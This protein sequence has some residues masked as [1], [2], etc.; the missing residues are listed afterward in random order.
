MSAR[1]GELS[2]VSAGREQMAI[3]CS[4]WELITDTCIYARWGD[5]ILRTHHHHCYSPERTR[6]WRRPFDPSH[7]GTHFLQPPHRSSQFS[8]LLAIPLSAFIL[9]TLHSFHHCQR[10]IATP[11]PLPGPPKSTT[12]LPLL[13]G[14]LLLPCHPVSTPFRYFLD[15]SSSRGLVGRYHHNVGTG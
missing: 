4:F 13:S 10:D 11:S 8:L 2:G 9:L 5:E 12:L 1:C 15:L 7:S 6:V 3:I 14:T